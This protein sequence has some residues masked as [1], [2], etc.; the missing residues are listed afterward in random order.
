MA[1]NRIKLRPNF[2]K[3]G[4]FVLKLKWWKQTRAHRQPCRSHKLMLFPY[5]RKADQKQE[6]KQYLC[7]LDFELCKLL[8]DYIDTTLSRILRLQYKVVKF[9]AEDRKPDEEKQGITV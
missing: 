9:I 5:G 7:Q 4:Q 3:I 8:V 2:V 6:R 1:S